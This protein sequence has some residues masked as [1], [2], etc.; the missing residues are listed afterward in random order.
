M[1]ELFFFAIMLGII[2]ILIIK[3][4]DGEFTYRDEIID[5]QNLTDEDGGLITTVYTIK[6]TYNSS[7]IKIIK[8]EIRPLN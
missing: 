1:V 2:A 6:R 8:T 4:F 3:Y 5:I 7:R